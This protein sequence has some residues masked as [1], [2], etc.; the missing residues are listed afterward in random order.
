VLGSFYA[1]VPAFLL[2]WLIA[3][4]IRNEEELLRKGL[5]GYE[6]YMRKVRFRLIPFVW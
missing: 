3:M 1:L 5:E 6:A 4:R 2:P